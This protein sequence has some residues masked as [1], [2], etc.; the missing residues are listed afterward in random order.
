MKMAIAKFEVKPAGSR[1][2]TSNPSQ[3]HTSWEFKTTQWAKLEPCT[4][5]PESVARGSHG[6]KCTPW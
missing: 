5:E 2:K 1:E 6:M 4:A 3:E